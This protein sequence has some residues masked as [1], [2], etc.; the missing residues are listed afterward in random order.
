MLLHFILITGALPA[1]ELLPRAASTTSESVTL[2]NPTSGNVSFYATANGCSSS[3]PTPISISVNTA[4]TVGTVTGAPATICAGSVITYTATGF[5]GGSF[6]MFQYQ[7]NTTAGTWNNWG[8]TN[9]YSWTSD[10]SGGTILYVRA[11]IVSGSCTFLFSGG[12]NNYS[13]SQQCRYG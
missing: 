9:P 3:T 12:V 6:S 8:T 10:Q 11:V 5:S 7:W 4:P 13:Y 1:V 2:N